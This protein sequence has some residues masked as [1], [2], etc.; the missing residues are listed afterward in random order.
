MK[1][2]TLGKVITL[3]GAIVAFS[4]GAGFATGQEILQFFASYGVAK[5]LGAAAVTLVLYIWVCAVIMEDARELQPKQAND[6]W[7]YYCG[8]YFGGFMKYFTP[9]FLFA[10]LVVMTSGAG[11][12]IN[13]Y[14]GLPTAVGR[15]LITVLMLVTV[16][17]GK[18]KLT[19][20]LGGVGI[21]IIIFALLVGIIS[22]CKNAG[23]L[24]TATATLETMDVAQAAPFWWLSGILYTTFMAVNLVPFLAG[25]APDCKSKEEARLGGIGGGMGMSK[26]VCK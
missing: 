4:I 21:I 17:L 16:I 12:T 3:T 14:Y 7:V 25:I 6:I 24:G 11:A 5:C 1:N 9:I 8:K 13:Q 2:I 19:K 15:G 23:N 26:N 10:V 22:L 18:D 20:I